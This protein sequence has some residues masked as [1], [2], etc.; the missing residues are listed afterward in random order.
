M[1]KNME[2]SGVPYLTDKPMKVYSSLW[3][4]DQWATRGGAIKTNWTEA[5]FKTWFRNFKARGCVSMNGWSSCNLA[6]SKVVN[7]DWYKQKELNSNS[8]DMLKW[9]QSNH[10]VYD[11]CNDFNRFPQGPPQECYLNKL[12]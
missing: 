12:T 10:M 8:K 4:G 1:F 6:T 2:S 11:Y 5:P 7:H 3:N 9:V